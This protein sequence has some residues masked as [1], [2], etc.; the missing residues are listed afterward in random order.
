[1]RIWPYGRFSSKP[2]ELGDSR[3]RQDEKIS[4]WIQ[5][6][7]YDQTMV[8]QTIFDS[9]LSGFHG[10]H[11][12]DGGGLAQILTQIQ[13][14]TIAQGD[15][16]LVENMDRLSRLPPSIAQEML[17]NIINKRI[18]VCII[19]GDYEITKRKYDSGD[20]TIWRVT[21]EIDRAHRESQRKSELIQGS[22][23]TKKTA[24]K[25]GLRTKHKAPWWVTWNE[26][27]HEYD[28]I[29]DHAET[30]RM[31]YKWALEGHG[32][33]SIV[34]LLNE[35]KRTPFG[36]S[37]E[38]TTVYVQKI[39]KARTVLGEMQYYK[40]ERDGKKTSVPDGDPIADYYPRVIDDETWSQVAKNRNEG[41]FWRHG[42]RNNEVPNLIQGRVVCSACGS[43]MHLVQSMRR[44]ANGTTRTYRHYTC[45]RA[46]DTKRIGCRHVRNISKT[47]VEEILVL[48]LLARGENLW[49]AAD[50][51][52]DQVAQIKPSRLEALTAEA[53]AL[54][55]KID[56]WLDALGDLP[57]A[58]QGNIKAK[59]RD[60]QQRLDQVSVDLAD[61][62]RGVET[63]DAV[64][65][66]L[67][68]LQASW[69]NQTRSKLQAAISKLVRVVILDS[70]TRTMAIEPHTGPV[71][72]ITNVDEWNK[73]RDT[74][75]ESMRLERWNQAIRD[76]SGLLSRT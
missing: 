49:Q 34:G 24:G 9:G 47:L 5:A 50:H 3:R 59:I 39:L 15:V 75:H 23:R 14:G 54:R 48:T 45:S 8:Q 22:W 38:W 53:E 16:I 76:V 70:E 74:V 64:R 1:M 62:D 6:R 37:K 72:T 35:H 57:K 41:A 11:L 44:L 43:A 2:Q 63:G 51:T 29:P 10:D 18:T 40:T 32:S 7:G 52:A 25:K 68:D 60:A 31:I 71:M 36:G 69:A 20:G 12:R 4:R 30:I 66:T 26:E 33:R 67:E 42:S 17:L 65:Q 28:L 19:D 58:A 56:N 21:G 46:R 55:T 13:G 61:L 27:R 73:I